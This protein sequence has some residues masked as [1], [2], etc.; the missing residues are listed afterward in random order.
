MGKRD[1]L[2]AL[3]TRARVRGLLAQGRSISAI[4]KIIGKSYQHT[5]RLAAQEQQT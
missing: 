5:K 2:L 3:I 1:E 4:A